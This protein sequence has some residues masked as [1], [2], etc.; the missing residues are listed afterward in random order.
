[1][2]HLTEV[3]GAKFMT[4]ETDLAA[5]AAGESGVSRRGF[6]AGTVAVGAALTVG[7]IGEVVKA[8]AAAAATTPLP[9]TTEPEQL[10]LT[11]GS[12]PSTQVTVWWASPGPIAQPAPTLAYSERPI[13]AE[14]PGKITALPEPTP[15]D[16]TRL[17]NRPASVSF[18]DGGSG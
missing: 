13:T 5:S 14:N 10:H 9:A 6:L 11:W 7:G 16:P 17:R 8:P 4:T 18:T 1:H 12:D 3:K 2:R 15:L